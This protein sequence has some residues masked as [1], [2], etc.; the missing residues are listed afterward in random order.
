MNKKTEPAAGG[1]DLSHLDETQY[2]VTQEQATEAPGSGEHLHNRETGHY[3]CIVCAQ[4]LFSSDK[5]Y[6]SGS[7]WPSFSDPADLGNVVCEFDESHGM[8]RVEVRCSE[9][10]A[11]LGHV[12]EDGPGAGGQ[13]YCINSAALGF[14]KVDDP[15]K[16]GDP[17]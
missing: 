2:K 8:R 12:F 17:D 10:D 16:S 9:C 14:A 13:R 15:D 3:H 11:H 7:G 4:A 6:D 5:K 1:R